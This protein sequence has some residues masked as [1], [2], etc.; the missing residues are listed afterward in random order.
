MKRNC[1]FCH[2]SKKYISVHG[3]FVRASD[4]KVLTRYF[5]THCRKT[6]SEA[7][8]HQNYRQKKRRLHPRIVEKICSC[9]SQ[10]RIARTLKI[11]RTTVA[12]KIKL[13]A[14]QAR[15]KQEKYLKKR[16]KITQFQFDDLETFEHSKCKPL[17]V[18]MAVEARTRKIIDFRVSSMP[19][20]GHLVKIALKKYG[21][22]EDQRAKNREELF[23]QL[24]QYATPEAE[25][26]SD[27]SPHYP[28]TVKRWF[29]KAVHK[30]TK[31]RRGCV[32]GQGEL[33]SGGFDPLFSLNHTFASLRDNLKRLSRRTWCTT[34]KIEGLKSQIDIYVA[35]HNFV[36]TK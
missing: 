29:P 6:F 28:E 9:E 27:Q 12:R 4:K 14:Q 33:K 16:E 8:F 34:K 23:A 5:C 36:L 1:P 3:H 18:T 19:A 2:T 17:S 7:T 24:C 35:Y 31:G 21:P 32:V 15:I 25:I 26:W 13:L 11:S 10:R 22:R 20:K 30:T